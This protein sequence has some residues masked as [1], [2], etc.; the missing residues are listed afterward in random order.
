MTEK[1]VVKR[2]GRKEIWS[3][4]KINQVCIWA[5]AG[6]DACPS[7]IAMQAKIK[8]FDG[9]TSQD[10]HESL[11]KSAADLVEEY[12]PDFTIAAARLRLFN[13][14]KRAYGDFNPPELLEHVKEVT[15][16]GWYDQEILLKWS[17]EEFNELDSYI[18]HNRDLDYKYAAIT[19]WDKKYLVQNR[20]T[21]EIFE[22]PQMAIMLCGMCLHQEEPKDKRLQYVKDFYDE[23]SLQNISLPT[24]INAGVRTPSRQFSSCTLIEMGDSLDSINSVNSAILKY[25]AN[26]AGIGVNVGAIRGE[27]FPIRGGEARHTGLVGVI[28]HIQAALWPSQGGVRKGSANLFYPWWHYDV[29]QLIVLKNNRGTEDTRARHLDYGIQFN[30]FFYEK[31]KNKEPLYL[32]SPSERSQQLYEAFFG[33]QERFAELYEELS[34]DSRVVKKVIDSSKFAD[35]FCQERAQ[36]GRIYVQNVDHCN[37]NSPFNIVLKMSNLCVEVILPTSPLSDDNPDEGEIAL[38][39]LAAFNLGN[40]DEYSQ[41]EKRAKVIVR[42][43]DNLLDY[44]GYPV[45]AAEKNKLRRTLGVGVINYAYALAKRGYKYSDDK[46]NNFTHELFESIQFY[47]L[48]ASKELAEEKGACELFCDTT[49][50]DGVLPVDRYKKEIDLYH[51]ASLKCDWEWLRSE[52][53]SKGLRNSTVTA[54]MPAETSAQISNATNGIEPPRGAKSV[55]DDQDGKLPQLVPDIENLFDKYEYKWEQPN[56]RGYLTKVGIMQKFNDQSISANTQYD[57][58][59]YDGGRI[60]TSVIMKDIMFAYHLGIKTLYYHETRDGNDQDVESCSGGGCTI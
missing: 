22:S 51:T 9:I 27:K 35:I 37:T 25:A 23:V 58:S 52:I 32:F 24:P 5:C 60:P 14:R 38:C 47:L 54:I 43:L 40:V 34:K 56:C 57:P 41:L 20:V 19:Q 13:I 53:R 11:Y 18:D 6:T 12:E 7:E 28:Q 29:E 16:L 4:E 55:K 48:K 45:K 1:Y 31:V 30:K 42:A 2:N 21:G 50:S 49:Y 3:D 10:I 39:T 44:Q 36:T 15:A 33:D 46:G 59:K 26:R 17:E 8:Y